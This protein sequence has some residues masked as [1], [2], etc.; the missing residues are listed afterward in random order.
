MDLLLLFFPLRRDDWNTT[1]IFLIKMNKIQ[2]D[3]LLG[4]L[5]LTEMVHD[6][7]P[8]NTIFSFSFCDNHK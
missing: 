8:N 5:W 7:I 6:K 4:S 1:S 3:F 2:L